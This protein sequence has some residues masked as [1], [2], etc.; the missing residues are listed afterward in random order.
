[1]T[2]RTMLHAQ[3]HICWFQDSF[4]MAQH[5]LVNIKLRGFL[6]LIAMVIP[7]PAVTSTCRCCLYFY[8]TRFVNTAL[9]LIVK[10]STCS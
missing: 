7:S 5:V 8:R 2:Y 3:M 6:V 9:K 1:M 10:Q 4:Q